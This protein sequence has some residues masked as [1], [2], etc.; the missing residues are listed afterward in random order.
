MFTS[1]HFETFE[2]ACALDAYTREEEG[3]LFDARFALASI[4]ENDN[5][6]FLRERFLNGIDERL[7]RLQTARLLRQDARQ[8]HRKEAGAAE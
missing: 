4:F 7:S 2:V 3:K 8:T 6:R 1:R 5:P